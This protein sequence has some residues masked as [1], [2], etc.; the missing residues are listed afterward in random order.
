MRKLIGEAGEVSSNPL[1]SPSLCRVDA[2]IFTLGNQPRPD[3]G[4]S[5]L[6]RGTRAN[7]KAGDFRSP[8]LHSS[9]RIRVVEETPA[10]RLAA[11]GITSVWA[12]SIAARR[13]PRA[14][15]QLFC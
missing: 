6:V 12:G 13:L 8:V 9:G 11:P 4:G 2:G 14:M 5:A 1:I 10:R 7:E 15:S 3:G